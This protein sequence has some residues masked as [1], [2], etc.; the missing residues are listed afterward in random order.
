MKKIRG[1]HSQQRDQYVQRAR[2]RGDW[3]VLGGSKSSVRLNIRVPEGEDEGPGR[4]EGWVV[5]ALNAVLRS[6]VYILRAM[7]NQG[8]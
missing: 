4:W 3:Y 1:E 8:K 2:E 5:E 6:P 7:E